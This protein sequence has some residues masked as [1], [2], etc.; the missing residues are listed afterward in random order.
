MNGRVYDTTVG[1]FLYADTIIHYMYNTQ[2]FNRYSYVRNI[3]IKS[4]CYKI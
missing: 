2:S 4:F 1:R 3:S